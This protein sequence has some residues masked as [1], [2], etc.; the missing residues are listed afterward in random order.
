MALDV[1]GNGRTLL[2]FR[3]GGRGVLLERA[4]G[5]SRLQPVSAHF[6]GKTTP[7]PTGEAYGVAVGDDGTAVVAWRP[8][9]GGRPGLGVLT[10]PAGGTFEL[11]R[12][13]EPEGSLFSSPNSTTLYGIS[14]GEKPSPPPDDRNADLSVALAADGRYAVGWTVERRLPFGDRPRAARAL[15]GT[16]GDDP[17]R[18]VTLGCA[19]RAVNG[20]AALSALDGPGLAFTDNV[21]DGI[22]PAGGGR[23]TLARADAKPSS[24][25]PAPRLTLRVVSQTLRFAQ[26]L[27][28]RVRC[29]RACEVR[30]LVARRHRGRRRGG[31]A[32]PRGLGGTTLTRAGSARLSISP[33][34]LAALAPR[35]P[36]RVRVVVRAYAADGIRHT[37]RSA[38]V[39][40]TRR[41]P[42]PLGPLL[43]VRARRVARGVAVRWRFPEVRRNV[44][45]AV[46][47]LRR[48]NGTPHRF[49]LYMSLEAKGRHRFRVLLRTRPGDRLRFV[50]VTA[51]AYPAKPRQVVVPIAPARR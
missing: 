47:G 36:Q 5:E 16:V 18:P 12:P 41:L 35:R 6:R 10:R 32:S 9:V 22:F 42:R 31:D 40:L 2:L 43:D 39:R 46:E 8:E 34:P 30:G 27:T 24:P 15:A 48:P 26:P 23:L 29:D 20:V 17:G 19:C 25:T 44:I 33:P 1:A 14:L 21:D 28:L 37:T 7:F 3:R 51:V 50:R 13:V 49:R 11:R 45:F 4:P 38:W